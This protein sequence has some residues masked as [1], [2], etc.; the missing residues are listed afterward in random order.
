[1]FE[2]PYARCGPSSCEPSPCAQDCVAETFV[3]AWRRPD[4]ALDDAARIVCCSSGVLI[5]LPE[6]F[7]VGILGGCLEGSF[8]AV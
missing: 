6:L 2:A 1:L 5:E 3:I 8:R 4:D 7:A